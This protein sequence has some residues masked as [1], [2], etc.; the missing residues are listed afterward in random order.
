MKWLNT[1]FDIMKN[2]M[3]QR[4]MAPKA[5]RDDGES[6]VTFRPCSFPDAALRYYAFG[7]FSDNLCPE[8]SA[9]L[10]AEWGIVKPV[11]SVVPTVPQ[12]VK[13]KAESTPKTVQKA[14]AKQRQL[15]TA[16]KGTSSI[17]S[18]FRA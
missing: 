7:V 18:F 13:R 9:E 16:S 11:T 6:Y 15:K 1:R 8:L 14:L 4:N 5:I 12:P 2:A 17:V 3:L 10:T